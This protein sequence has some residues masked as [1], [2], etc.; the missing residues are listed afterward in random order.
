MNVELDYSPKT[1][2]CQ[3][4]IDDQYILE[5]L[6][7]KF[8][9]P[10]EA[11]KFN[12]GPYRCFIPDYIHFITPTGRFSFGLAEMILDWLK[13]NVHDRVVNYKFTDDFKKRFTPEEENFELENRL[14]L[15]PRDYQNDVVKLALKHRFGT[16]VMGTG[17][18]KTLTI[19]SIIDNLFRLKK[20][21]RCLILVPDNGLVIQFYDELKE[22]YGLNLKISTF[23]GKSN[24]ID[25]DA[26]LI[27][28]NRP[29][30][31]A[32]FGANQD[33]FCNEIDCLVVDEAHSLK[34]G[35]KVSKM[36][37]KV[38]AFYRFGF[39]GTLAENLE[40]KY[41]NLGLLGPVRYEK[42]SKELR[43]EGFLANVNV[44][45]LVLHYSFMQKLSY[46]DEV[47]FLLSLPHRNRFISKLCF[48]MN[49]N[50][51]VL[52]NMLDHGFELEKIL[53]E[54]NEKEENKK[55]IFFIR[56]EVETD[57]REEVKK[58]M[59]KSDNVICIAVTKIFSTGI[60][61]KNLHNVMFAAGGKS[62]VT[63]VQSIG[64]G[65][66]LHPTKKMLNIW[67]LSD[68]GFKYSQQHAASRE[69]IYGVEKIQCKKHDINV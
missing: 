28:A 62:A 2:L 15:E 44:N 64:R 51:L 8:S 31:L 7:D 1:R 54:Q 12:K 35:N 41:R 48:K 22:Q 29:L 60:N 10:N 67:D 36:L 19:A 32:R 42:T 57:T 39:T 6:R 26:D 69:K 4:N 17:A 9:V 16:F 23:Y 61:I 59:E 27:I 43:D 14:K 38:N 49:K 66:R 65:L 68:Y 63:V 56:G 24:E 45:Q 33:F 21:K 25:K 55:Q 47:E 18:G 3:L 50:V 52:V 11:K 40:D 53:K 46:R 58:L 37:E 5:R 13:Q 34:R 30:F 20:I